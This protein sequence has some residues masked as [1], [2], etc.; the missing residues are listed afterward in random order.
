MKI[1]VV[2]FMLLTVL[3]VGMPLVSAQDAPDF[4][5]AYRQEY[6][7]TEE[8][9]TLSVMVIGDSRVEDMETNAFTAWFEDLTN[10]HV[11]WQVVPGEGATEALS[12]TLASG[13]LP[14]VILGFNLSM[15][16]LSVYGSQ[17]LFIPLNDLIEESGVNTQW[18]FEEVPD[19]PPQITALDGNIY[20]LPY[21]NVCGHCSGSQKM[22]INQTWLDALDLDMPQTTEEFRDVLI[23]F[24][25]GDPNGNGIQDE[26]PLSGASTGWHGQLRGFLIDPF[27]IDNPF[28][29]NPHLYMDNG[30]IKPNF[31]TE[32]YREALRYIK[33]LFDEG[34]VGSESLTQTMA[35]LI[36]QAENPEGNRLGAVTAGYMAQFTELGGESGR[37]EDYVT[38]PPLIGPSGNRVAPIEPYLLGPGAFMITS[39]AENPEIAFKWGDSFYEWEIETRRVYGIQGVD[40]D[41]V[42]EGSGIIAL[43]GEPACRVLMTP[44]GQLTNN[45]WFETG[46][47]YLSAQFRL[48]ESFDRQN[49][50][51]YFSF[52]LEDETIRNY[53]PYAADPE[54]VVPRIT[55]S[56]EDAAES[57]ELWSGI[58]S[59][60]NQMFAQ[61][62]T[63]QADLDADWDSYLQQ[64]DEL[65][66]PRYLELRQAAYEAQYGM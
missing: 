20:A 50:A 42:A 9:V 2:A 57:G 1:R 18:V 4:P 26:I 54:I 12:L 27:I 64:L 8:P 40:W 38:V 43:N 13:D 47:E 24:R 15:S 17:G 21:I 60:A 37:W 33:S 58:D 3:I 44:Y 16:T 56:E 65:G 45:H 14:D 6:P 34:L 25:D 30:E 23:A 49:I 36:P 63:G 62:V 55:L 19:L 51:S 61:F 7:L 46:P 5:W 32:E 31:V 11:N 53:F 35:D 52:I 59:F 10:V 29:D 48:C 66:L 41:Y 28:F 22:W 39:A